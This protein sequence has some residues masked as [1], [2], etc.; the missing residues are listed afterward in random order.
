[1][2]KLPDIRQVSD[3]DCGD[4]ALACTFKFFRRPA[5]PPVSNPADG[6]EPRDVERALWAAGFACQSGTMDVTDLRHH[7]ARGRPVLCLLDGHW[8]VSAGVERLSVYFQD[9]ERGPCKEKAPVFLTRWINDTYGQ[10][11]PW[12]RWGISVSVLGTW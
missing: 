7:A 5:P 10:G 9:P 3:Y 8:V 1:M 6:A 2:L 4:A 11:A 12:V